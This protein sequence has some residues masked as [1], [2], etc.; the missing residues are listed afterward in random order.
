MRERGLDYAEQHRGRLVGVV[1][2]ARLGRLFDVFHPLRTAQLEVPEGRPLGVSRAGLV[3]YWILV[4]FAVAGAVALHRRREQPLWPLLTPIGVAA[5][6]AVYSYGNV[7][8]RAVA[9]PVLVILATLGI[10]AL[11]RVVMRNRARVS[12]AP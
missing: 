2:W 3:M 8:F 12:V 1:V 7:R 6:V 4:P 9:E 11:R 10:D 5:L